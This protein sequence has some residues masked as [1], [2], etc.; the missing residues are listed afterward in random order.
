[1]VILDESH[2]IKVNFLGKKL[3]KLTS[4]KCD[5]EKALNFH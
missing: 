5:L 2:Q 3:I 4:S 1:M